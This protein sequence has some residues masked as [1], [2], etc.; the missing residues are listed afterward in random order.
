M[1]F[2]PGLAYC[3]NLCTAKCMAV[4]KNQKFPQDRA[5]E[6]LYA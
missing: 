1:Q 4:H 6:L 5:S 2:E 3:I